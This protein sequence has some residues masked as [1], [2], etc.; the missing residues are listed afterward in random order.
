[1]TAAQRQLSA[2]LPFAMPPVVYDFAIN[3]QGTTGRLLSPPEALLPAKYYAQHVPAWLR[4]DPRTLSAQRRDE[5]DRFGAAARRGAEMTGVIETLFERILPRPAREGAD[6]ERLEELLRE[7]GFDREQHDRAAADL[8][9][10]RIGL[11][12]NRLPPSTVVGD[13]MP[14]TWP[15][16]PR[17]GIRAP[18]G[19]AGTRCGRGRWP[20]SRSP[21]GPAAAGPRARG[22]S[23][24]CTR[25]ASSPAGTAPSWRFTSPRAAAPGRPAA[26]SR[27]TWSPR[28][29]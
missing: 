23:R 18:C 16:F 11:S 9:R 5:L 10:G 29:I 13:A 28:G 22:R 6:R 1:M 15:T 24:R 27:R 17:R 3:W 4:Q 12:Q 26:R 8:K 25:S 2:A 19:S 7:H 20:W 14:G 21:A